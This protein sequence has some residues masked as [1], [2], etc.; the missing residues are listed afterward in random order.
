MEGLG[1]RLQALRRQSNLSVRALAER[2][3]V[4]VSYVYAIEAGLRGH[5]LVKLQRI[6]NALGVPLSQLWGEFE[7]DSARGETEHGPEER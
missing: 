6:A 2:A 3:G 4:S 7:Q 1:T 5:N